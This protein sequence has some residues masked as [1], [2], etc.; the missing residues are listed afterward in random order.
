LRVITKIERTASITTLAKLALLK[1]LENHI[2]FGECRSFDEELGDLSHVTFAGTRNGRI[3]PRL[4][5][6]SSHSSCRNS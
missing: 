4:K 5:V 3:A 6:G 1:P 2:V